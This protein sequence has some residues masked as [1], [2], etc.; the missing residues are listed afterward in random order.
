MKNARSIEVAMN[1]LVEMAGTIPEKLNFTGSF[2]PAVEVDTNFKEGQLGKSESVAEECETR[3][4]PD[5]ATSRGATDDNESRFD[6]FVSIEE[7]ASNI[8]ASLSSCTSDDDESRFEEYMSIEEVASTITANLSRFSVE[9]QNSA[10]EL[11]KA[12]MLAVDEHK[13][14][15]SLEQTKAISPEQTADASSIEVAM[16]QLV[17]IAGTIPEKLN[18]TGSFHPAV[19]VNVNVKEGQLGKSETVVEECEIRSTPDQTTSRG[20]IDAN[21]SR[22]DEFVSIEEVAS[23]ITAN[24]SSFSTE[25]QISAD[26]LTKTLMVAVDKCKSHFSPEQTK[27]IS[28]EEKAEIQEIARAQNDL[29]DE[30][31]EDVQSAVCSVKHPVLEEALESKNDLLDR[32]FE[33]LEVNICKGDTVIADEDGTNLRLHEKIQGIIEKLEVNICKGDIVIA[34]EDGTN[35]RLHEKI[36][37]IHENSLLEAEGDE[38]ASQSD[39]ERLHEKI[40]VIHENSLLEADGD[41]TA[42]RCD[43]ESQVKQQVTVPIGNSRDAVIDRSPKVSDKRICA[44]MDNAST[45]SSMTASQGMDKYT[46]EEE[47]PISADAD[48]EYTDVYTDVYTEAAKGDPDNSMKKSFAFRRAISITSSV[49]SI[50][51]RASTKPST[52]FTPSMKAVRPTRMIVKRESDDDSASNDERRITGESSRGGMQGALKSSQQLD[53]EWSRSSSQNI[54]LKKRRNVISKGLRFI[55]GRKDKR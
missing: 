54:D 34:D 9:A 55:F 31:F 16:N 48:D 37:V 5:E 20:A 29:L 30:V 47:E 24:L 52:Y 50:S 12:L 32:I 53:D 27:A 7:V 19:E 51:T 2:H 21:E 22:F 45:T 6:D 3:S 15:L 38:M 35:L 10:D 17:E 28:P 18:C 36:Q 49:S 46:V 13:S 4:I 44:D 40:Q 1:Q 41:E 14:L 39:E 43:E 23:N 33:K 42:S 11:A 8:T 25:A 26:E